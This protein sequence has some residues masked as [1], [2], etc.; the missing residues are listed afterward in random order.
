EE[1]E[2]SCEGYREQ[3][4]TLASNLE[5]AEEKMTTLAEERYGALKEVEE[6]KAKIV[7]MEG[8]LQESAGAAVVG[9]DEKEV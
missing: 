8:K 9:G 6:L 5:K 3:H 1:S 2:A 4:K 7:E